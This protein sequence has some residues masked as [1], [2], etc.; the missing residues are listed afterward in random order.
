RCSPFTRRGLTAWGPGPLYYTMSYTTSP[1]R[2]DGHPDGPAGRGNGK[3]AG[4]DRDHDGP[5][6]VRGDEEGPACVAGRDR[7][8]RR[9]GSVRRLQ[10]PGPRSR[11]I[12]HRTGVRDARGGARGDPP[13]A[14]AVILLDTGPIVA[15]FDPRDASH[16]RCRDVLRALREPLVTTVPVLTEAFHM[17]GPGSRGSNRA[18][19]F[20]AGGGATV[21][22]LD[23]PALVRAFELVERYADHPMDLADASLIVAGET[24]AT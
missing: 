5:V 7:P 15:L 1:G 12:C 21:W 18:R 13:Q 11:R 16:P 24:L 14:Q 2:R 4:A 8:G 3:S 23:A 22:F 19:D 17:L 20:I 10:R 9:P 6:G